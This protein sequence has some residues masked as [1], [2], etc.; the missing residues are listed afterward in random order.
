MLV[1]EF[2][3]VDCR[4]TGQPEK[5]QGERCITVPGQSLGFVSDEAFFGSDGS[6]RDQHCWLDGAQ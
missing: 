4:H 2:T 1:A 3:A 5:V 6:V